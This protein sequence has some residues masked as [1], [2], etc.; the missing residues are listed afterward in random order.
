MDSRDLL[1]LPGD[2]NKTKL[3]YSYAHPIS[4]EAD[5]CLFFGLWLYA[6]ITGRKDC[7]V[8]VDMDEV[9]SNIN[10]REQ[11]LQKLAHIDLSSIDLSDAN[12][13]RA[14]FTERERSF[15]QIIEGQVLEIF[16]KHDI[17]AECLLA[18][19]EYLD[20]RRAVAF[21]IGLNEEEGIPS[22][23]ED[24]AR[25]REVLLSSSRLSAEAIYNLNGVVAERDEQ[26]AN[27]NQTLAER[28]EQIANA[29]QTLA[30][31]DEQIANV[32]QTLAERDEQI[33]NVNQTLAERDEHIANVN[34]T[35]AERDEQIANANQTLA[36]RDEQIANVNQTLAERDEHI[37]NVNQALAERD[38]QFGSLNQTVTE[39]NEQV[40]NINQALAERDEQISNF[41]KAIAERDR[42]IDDLNQTLAEHD[43]HIA[44]LSDETV[45]RGEWALRLDLELKEERT[46]LLI[47]TK[48]NS[49]R[50][51]LPLREARRWVS[52]PKQQTKRYVTETLRIIKPIYQAL[53]LDYQTKALHRN[54]LAKYFPG[55]LLRSGSHQTTIPVLSIPTSNTHKDTTH[56][57]SEQ[58]SAFSSDYASSIVIPLSKNPL[59]SVIIPIYGKVDYTLRCLASIAINL[60]QSSFEIIV[61]DDCSPDN[62]A[63]ILS[64]VNGIRLICNEQNQGFIRSCNVGANAANGEYLYFLNNDTEVTLGWMD[65]LVRTFQEF[66]KTGL[67][68]SKLI[69]PDGRLQEAGGIIWQDGS[70]WNFGRFQDPLLPIYNY[71]REVDY[72]SGASIMVPKVLFTE[73]G[74]FDEQYLPAY[75]EDS[76]LA[77]KIR[78]RDYRVIYQ[79]LSTVIHYEGVTS[80]TDTS[81]GT[82]AYQIENSKKLFDRWK[83]HLQTHQPAGMDADNAKDR[84]ATRRALVIDH[85]TPT[86]NQDAGSITV[87]N[88]ILLLREMDFQVTFIPEDNFLYMPEYTTELQRAGIEVLYAPFV[89]NVEQHVKDCGDRYDLAFLFRPGVVT[90]HLKMIR[91]FC[92]KAKVL[93][94]TVDLHFL[95][96]SREAELQS[97]KV[98]QKEADKMKQCELA[99]IRASDASIVHSTA[100]FELL[101]AE[102]P[103]AILHV[104]P[105][106]MNVQGTSIS[107]S[108][109]RDIVFV[110][111]Y[112]HT[113]NVDAVHY[114]VTEVMPLLRK[115]LPGVRF[116]AVGSKPPADIQALA[117]EDIIIT[118]FVEDLTPLL[119]KMRVSV[120]PLRFGAGIKGKIGSAIAVGLPVVATPLA[121]EGMLLTDGENILVAEGAKALADAVVKI[122][123]DEVLWEK[124]SQNGLTFAENS[125]GAEA[126]FRILAD[127]L[128]GLSIKVIRNNKPLTLYA[129]DSNVLTDVDKKTQQSSTNNIDEAYQKKIQQ[130]LAIYEKQVNVHDL[131]DI[132]HYWSNKYLAPIFKDAGFS[133]IAQFFSSNLF[134]AK[135]RTGSAIATFISVGAGNCDLEVSV[136]K[137]L[138]NSGFNDFI[139][140][141]L[142]I[143]PVMLD[144]G[145][146][147]AKENGVLDNMSFVEADF[148]TWVARKKYDGVIANQSL[149]HVTRLEHLFDQ[150]SNALHANGSFIISDMIGRNGHQRWPESLKIVNKF[151]K[152][153]PESYKFNVLLN[154][155]EKKYDNWD[156]SK[157][158]FEGVRAQDVLPLL[159]QRFQCE[160]FIGFGSAI[161]IFVDRCFGHNFNRE[162]EWDRDFID[163]VHT[164]DEAGLANGTL[165]P[166]H[167]MAIFVKK[168][169]CTPYYSRE[170]D[171]TRSV[172]VE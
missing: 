171:P 40:T 108:E 143:N 16:R 129:P 39:L 34:Q 58:D 77:L 54:F 87:L 131:P 24:A 137:N 123:Q 140:E 116:Y 83:E 25:M 72:C 110:G 56:E 52:T 38:E 162:S 63:N 166:T 89:T 81:Q 121:A 84:R 95:R 107:F 104:F 70:A 43:G 92:P 139:L 90:R 82:K 160:K 152:E 73:L 18:A 68:G 28:D 149:H 64:N 113:P 88:L 31:R 154:R 7:D 55:I 37:A 8:V 133:T 145:K 9:S 109:R 156:C 122:Y 32:N 125:W 101:H 45:R 33:A 48:S 2:D 136:A 118:G 153:L 4:P 124:I 155:L 102:L 142:E 66:P 53:P 144:R 103:D 157:E 172:R 23:L 148:N 35:L 46:R 13:H 21:V 11:I 17:D 14:I 105:L 75:C 138:V 57:I 27:V 134:E 117:S 80:G 76:D 19:R 10:Y 44:T 141:C 168:L 59:V 91:K 85:C 100:E 6:Y 99:A 150:I 130:E 47:I 69:Y 36:E 15:Y 159:L 97:D 146:E 26:I 165:T 51:T 158:G 126:A 151:W 132:Y 147:I 41:N 65:E 29:N 167:M 135:N 114:F 164:E 127:I 74:G 60:P 50:L 30:E 78:A 120:A 106:I 3:I 62:S 61:V 20:Q 71:A 93:Y 79:P 22:T 111:G 42:Q 94:H 96:M 49:W 163:R 112:Q 128:S 86:P 98:K 169:H 12:L 161:D 119:D 1:C 170:I 67:V 115:Q 5:Y